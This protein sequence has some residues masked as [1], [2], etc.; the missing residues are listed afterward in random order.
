MNTWYSR[1][2]G[3]A[4]YE[5]DHALQPLHGFFQALA[6]REGNPPE[7]AI[8]T[9]LESEGR[10]HCELIVYF[11]PAAREAA[12]IFRAHPCRKPSRDG[13]DLF[14][15]DERAWSAL[16]PESKPFSL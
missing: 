4:I 10:L 7:M 15:G 5:A 2:L 13:L 1:N 8:F 12:D 9:R 16:F 11:A 14:A 3:D 6:A